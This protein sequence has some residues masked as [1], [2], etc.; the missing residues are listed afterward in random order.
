MD[1]VQFQEARQTLRWAAVGLMPRREV[2]YNALGSINAQ[3]VSLPQ[4]DQIR[5]VLESLGRGVL[6]KQRDCQGAAEALESLFDDDIS[7][8]TPRG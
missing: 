6:P 5:V 4:D 3:G 1:R 7:H 8:E 2:A